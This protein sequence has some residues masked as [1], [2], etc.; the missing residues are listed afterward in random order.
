MVDTVRGT[1]R[2][3]KWP[4]KYGKARSALQAWWIDWFKQANKLAKYADGMAQARAIEMTKGTGLYPRDVMLS[5]MRG[6]LYVWADNTGKKYY[7]MAAVQDISDSLDVLAQ[8]VGSV[9][10]RAVDR[11]RAPDPGN[12]G[13]VLTYQ[14][15][16]APADWQPAAGGGGF[17]GGALVGKSANQNIAAWGNAAI[18][19]QAESYD[20]AAIYNPAA[21]T[22]LTVPVGF[23][24]VRLTTNMYANAGSGQ[25]V[26]TR[27]FKNGAELPGGCHVATPATASAVVQ[28]NGL[29]SP[30][31]VIP[32]DYFEVNV[33]NGTGSTRVIQGMVNR[34]WFAMELL[35]AI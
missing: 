26:L 18:T 20:T 14:G 22:R 19:F 7:P 15:S 35:S 11:W 25:V 4:K 10:V 16:S 23:D 9:L 6:R 17:L 34:T 32:G 24:L 1:L 28:H 3:R 5:A 33:Y 21:P 12:P 27:I 30:V 8:T 29:T 2:V 31:T 13:D